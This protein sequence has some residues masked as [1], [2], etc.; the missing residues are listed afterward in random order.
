MGELALRVDEDA[1]YT[2]RAGGTEETVLVAIQLPRVGGVEE[3]LELAA[4]QALIGHE[5]VE[6]LHE[7]GLRKG[8]QV[9]EFGVCRVRAQR[10]AVVV[11]RL[12]NL[13]EQL[14]QTRAL[15]LHEPPARPAV[16]LEQLECVCLQCA[17]GE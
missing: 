14:S 12:E 1:G 15:V 8:R 3:R 10:L 5:V 4:A 17:W 9:G 16:A 6:L 7:N 2:A 11:G 13:L